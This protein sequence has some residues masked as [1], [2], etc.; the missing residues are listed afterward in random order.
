MLASAMQG[1]GI[2]IRTVRALLLA[3][4]SM[5][6]GLTV[7]A[8]TCTTVLPD[9]AAFP[10]SFSSIVT[11]HVVWTDSS[12]NVTVSD[13]QFSGAHSFVSP[14][15]FATKV[16][17]LQGPD[18]FRR[19]DGVFP[20]RSGSLVTQSGILAITTTVTAGG[21]LLHMTED[22]R[23]NQS[24]NEQPCKTCPDDI[25]TVNTY[26]YNESTG[27]YTYATRSDRNSSGVDPSNNVS[28][29][30]LS[31]DSG[32]V[33][34]MV[35]IIIHGLT[36]TCATVIN[37]ALSGPTPSGGNLL[38]GP[39]Q[40][41]ATFTPTLNG[42]PYGLSQAAQLCGVTKFDWVQTITLVP[43]PFPFCE[44]NT[45][46]NN[47]Q[48]FC[49]QTASNSPPFPLH[50]T[51]HSAPFN[52]PPPSGYPYINQRGWDTGADAYPFYYDT[53]TS[54]YALSLD[55]PQ[56][57]ISPNTLQFFD[58]PNNPC[59]S[60]PL[61][62]PSFAYLFGT[63]GV[64]ASVY[65]AMCGNSTP[66]SLPPYSVTPASSYWYFTTHLAGVKANNTPL[67]FGIGFDWK[68]NF[69]GT[70]GGIATTSAIPGQPVDPNGVGGITV[71]SV[72]TT[73]TY[74]NVI[75]GGTGATLLTGSEVST[76]ASGLAYSRVSQ[77]F[78]GTV[79]ITN[80]SSGTL[81]GPFQVV[82]N[83]LTAGVTLANAA[84]NF[85]GWSYVAIPSITRLAPG[86]SATV[87]V[88]FK[89]PSNST[90]QFIPLTYVGSFL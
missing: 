85:G 45:T 54:G 6:V 70:F 43:D 16:F 40:I 58:S 8:Q 12:G 59:I 75:G 47:P 14:L 22:A 37:N 71:T 48:P 72:N 18:V 66:S 81:T 86:Q 90:I 62:V 9:A 41:T 57:T 5:M 4:L 73:T 52:D 31:V 21:G 35:P 80:I 2:P 88:Q 68:S 33:S 55:S 76:T 24:P 27:A 11:Q 39:T 30:Y 26:D 79:T 82:I 50:L 1:V 69:N 89:N 65:Q 23:N 49:G 15:V 60:G 77:T 78:N 74:E 53:Q 17:G 64:P 38:S 3:S 29:V 84:G 32:S 51:S 19:C 36:A 7:Q 20:S 28:Y 46:P 56:N 67:D 61:G 44:N 34:G 10:I 13:T 63:T 83:S 87:A 42:T 25:H